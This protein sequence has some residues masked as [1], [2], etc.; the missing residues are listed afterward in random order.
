MP[1][2]RC[3]PPPRQLSSSAPTPCLSAQDAFTA[4][5]RLRWPVIAAVQGA[6]VGAGVDLITACDVRYCSRDA[7]FVVK[8]VDVAITA[9]LVRAR[10]CSVHLRAGVACLDL[11]HMACSWHPGALAEACSEAHAVQP[12]TAVWA[13]TPEPSTG[14]VR[15][16]AAAF[17]LLASCFSQ[18]WLVSVSQR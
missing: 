15:P 9:D 18:H 12:E 4:L 10:G 14:V 1:A 3:S 2:A 6:C 5:E 7:Y 11:A 13:P 16:G 17:G 8:E